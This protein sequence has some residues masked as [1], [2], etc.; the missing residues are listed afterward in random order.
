[1]QPSQDKQ[2]DTSH[3]VE[4]DEFM[5]RCFHWSAPAIADHTVCLMLRSALV[6]SRLALHSVVDDNMG[7]PNSVLGQ[8]S[9]PVSRHH[10][11]GRLS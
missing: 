6:C 4:S 10:K 1:M 3:K 9:D 7:A 2:P 11:K 5:S 8:V